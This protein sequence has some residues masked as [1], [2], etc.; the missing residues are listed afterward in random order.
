LPVI[1]TASAD[2]LAGQSITASAAT[3]LNFMVIPRF[4]RRQSRIVIAANAT[5]R[6]ARK[7]AKG[8]RFQ[9]ISNGNLRESASALVCTAK[10]EPVR[11]RTS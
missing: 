8:A 4:S 9:S 10:L 5:L 1:R 7:S 11:S 6:L 2:A 3:K